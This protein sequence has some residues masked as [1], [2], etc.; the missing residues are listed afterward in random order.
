MTTPTQTRRR[1]GDPVPDLVTFL[2]FHTGLR[3]EFGRLA[4]VLDRCDPRDERRRAVVDE[5][6]A[7]LLR[8]LHHHHTEEDEAIWP[9]LRGL[10]PEAAATLDRLEADHQEMDTVIGRLSGGGRPAREVAADLRS[11][12][13]LLNT[14]L[15]L[16]ESE[17]VPLIR[18][19]VSAAWWEESG[20]KVTKSHAR[21]LPMLAAWL[22]DVAAP[23]DR[24]HIF[25]SAPAVMRV[26]YRLSW[27]RAYERRVSQVYG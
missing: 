8:A 21:D 23:A 25:G 24:D 3:R 19:H 12:D 7:L 13:R 2:V 11:L 14:H 10:V 1:P 15:D 18:E 16:E 9:L 26:L 5:H 17:V 6:L 20:K 22:L 27:R 4:E